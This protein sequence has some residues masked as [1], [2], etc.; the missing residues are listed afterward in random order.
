[1]NDKERSRLDFLNRGFRNKVCEAYIAYRKEIEG[2]IGKE[3]K[4]AD[5]LDEHFPGSS[6]AE[7]IRDGIDELEERLE[8]IDEAVS[9][10]VE[11]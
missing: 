7:S 6:Q 8:A 5:N 4:K 3:E 10:I 2:I 9:T 1:M 11:E